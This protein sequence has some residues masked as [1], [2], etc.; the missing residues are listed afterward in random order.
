MRE[1]LKQ[2]L[3]QGCTVRSMK[4]AVTE[5]TVHPGWARL[6]AD[7]IKHAEIEMRQ[8]HWLG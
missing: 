7:V 2:G 8:A 5:E 3:Q 1:V 4:H 6:N